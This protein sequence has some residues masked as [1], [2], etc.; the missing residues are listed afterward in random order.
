MHSKLLL[1]ILSSALVLT[2]NVSLN[3]EFKYQYEI[4]TNSYNPLDDSAGYYYKE[5]M[6]DRME[7]LIFLIE[8]KDRSNYIFNH[9]EEFKFSDDAKV[10]YQMGIVCVTLGEGKGRIIKGQ[11]RKNE[12]DEQVIREKYYILELFK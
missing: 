4:K 2:S 10:T 1:S 5:K 3:S 8:E 7:H 9:L 12:C 6:I 11:F